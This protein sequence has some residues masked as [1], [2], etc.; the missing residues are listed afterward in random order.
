MVWCPGV[1]AAYTAMPS[2]LGV[3]LRVTSADALVAVPT[4]V[5][6]EE[7]LSIHSAPELGNELSTAAVL[8]YH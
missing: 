2:Y 4:N 8:E 7:Q 1:K 5:L 3:Q 6:Y